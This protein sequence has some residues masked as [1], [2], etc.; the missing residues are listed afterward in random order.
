[1][2]DQVQIRRNTTAG[3][4]TF[5]AAPGELVADTTKNALYLGNGSTQP[6]VPVG[7]PMSPDGAMAYYAWVEGTV[8]L[9]AAAYTSI[10]LPT[11]P[12][13]AYQAIISAIACRVISVAVGSGAT[14]FGIGMTYAGEANPPSPDLTHFG[15]SIPLT[16]SQTNEGIGSPVSYYQGTT[17]FYVNA[18][19]GI[20]VAG[21]V[22]RISALALIVT[23]PTS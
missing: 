2:A 10:T 1:M 20:F 16:A 13:S 6:G 7:I 17:S 14:S 9:T 11:L 23:P 4:G 15:G 8:T 12:G 18:T 3:L 5:A 19:S 21:S 22:I